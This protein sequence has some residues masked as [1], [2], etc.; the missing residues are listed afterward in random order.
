[1]KKSTR[2]HW[3]F[4]SARKR[5]ILPMSCPGSAKKQSAYYSALTY[6]DGS[7]FKIKNITLGYT[8]P[9]N[10]VKKAF[11]E[12]VRFYATAYNPVIFCKSI[13]KNTDPETGGSDAFP[14]YR[15]FVFGVNVTF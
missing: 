4:T 13:L 5:N 2:M 1:M 3:T 10:L 14:T 15:E 11:M 9:T 8:L 6:V 12:R 7:F